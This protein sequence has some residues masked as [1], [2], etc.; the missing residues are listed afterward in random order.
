MAFK[1]PAALVKK[2]KKVRLIASDV[3]GVFTDGA[4]IL[5]NSGEEIKFW[6][7]KD[8]IGFEMLRKSKKRFY[9]AF[10]TGRKSRQVEERAAEHKL[11]GLY[12]LSHNKGAALRELMLRYK[13]AAEET[14]FIGDDLVDISAFRAAGVSIC[15][16]DAHSQLKDTCD[17]TT[18]AAGGKGVFR[19]VV[20]MVLRAQGL[21]EDV[22]AAYERP[23]NP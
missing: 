22:V 1:L 11:D 9:T 20:D 10:I 2:L 23:E 3:D 4:I 6:N 13:L 12:Q 17:F 18:E 8:R 5:L 15:P 7:A 16:H 14:L 21:W 19:E